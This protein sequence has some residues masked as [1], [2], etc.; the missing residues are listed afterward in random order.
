MHCDLVFLLVL[1][2]SCWLRITSSSC[3]DVLLLLFVPLFFSRC[4]IV[5]FAFALPN[6]FTQAT[7]LFFSCCCIFFSRIVILFFLPLLRCSLCTTSLLLLH[8]L[9]PPLML[10]CSSCVVMVFFSCGLPSRLLMLC[11]SS[12]IALAI[13]FALC[14]LFFWCCHVASVLFSHYHSFG[15]G[16]QP[17]S[18]YWANFWCC[19]S[20]IV[21]TSLLV[22][23][24][25]LF[26]WLVWYFHSPSYHMQVGALTPNSQAPK[27]NFFSFFF[28]FFCFFHF[29]LFLLIMW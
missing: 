19:F 17:S 15:V 7:T 11:C 27:V 24:L 9:A 20:H 8:C 2:S 6:C 25:F 4:C 16:A 29:V 23:L 3:V 5:L 26:P 13:L 1:F 10:F 18:T 12:Y 22:L 28:S 14:L 21:V